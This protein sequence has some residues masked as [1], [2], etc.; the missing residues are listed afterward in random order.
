VIDPFI[1]ALAID[2]TRLAALYVATGSGIFKSTNGGENWS[3]ANTSRNNIGEITALA[4]NPVTPTTLYAGI[5]GGMLFESPD[6]GKTWSVIATGL[7]SQILRT[8]RLARHS[9][10]SSMWGQM[11]TA[12][13]PFGQHIEIGPQ[14]LTTASTDHHG[15]DIPGIGFDRQERQ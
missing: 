2:P 3:A 5:R 6:S 9:Q 15:Q 12:C 4:F 8:W 11:A 7:T 13:L 10:P 14:K 1:D